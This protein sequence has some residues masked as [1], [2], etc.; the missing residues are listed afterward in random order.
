MAVGQRSRK[1]LGI[2]SAELLD[3]AVPELT[4]SGLHCFVNIQSSELFRQARLAFFVTRNTHRMRY[5]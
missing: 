1:V 4:A 5:Q 2:D 3:S